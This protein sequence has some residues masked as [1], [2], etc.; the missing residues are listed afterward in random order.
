MDSFEFLVFIPHKASSA[1][2]FHFP[3]TIFLF[4][5]QLT[6]SGITAMIKI[7]QIRCLPV[8]LN[9]LLRKDVKDM[10]YFKNE[11]DLPQR[12]GAYLKSEL[13]RRKMTQEEFADNVCVTP[14]TVRRWV[15]SVD[16]ITTVVLIADALHVSFLD[17]LCGA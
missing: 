15:Q 9:I 1:F 6:D 11:A 4:R 13:A 5:G 16:S 3:K 14:R 2:L 12:V 17:I 10:E 7:L 8:I